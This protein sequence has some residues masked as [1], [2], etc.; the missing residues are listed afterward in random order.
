[1]ELRAAI[2]ARIKAHAFP[3]GVD[4]A[5]ANALADDILSLPELRALRQKEAQEDDDVRRDRP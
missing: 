1:M 3:L 5:F 4:L 2:I